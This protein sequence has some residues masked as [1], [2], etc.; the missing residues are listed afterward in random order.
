MKMIIDATD[1]VLGRVAAF[2]VVRAKQGND[3]SVINCEK[4]VISG[5]KSYVY[6][7]Y[8]HR[9]NMGTPRHGPFLSRS[10]EMI[11]KRAIRGML[12]HKKASGKELLS[13]IK[14][15][16]GVPDELKDQKAERAP[17]SDI[18]KIPNTRFVR[19]SA[20]SNHLGGQ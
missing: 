18:S 10:P 14:C 2:A 8:E 11:M 19:V 20:L 12:E 4:A 15:Y 17:K 1:A 16:S 5:S 9:M 6:A 3:V 13:R 7:K